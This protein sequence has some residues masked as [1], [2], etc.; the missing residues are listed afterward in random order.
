MSDLISPTDS[1]GIRE[2]NV[3]ILACDSMCDLCEAGNG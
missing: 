2:M 1:F 3:Y